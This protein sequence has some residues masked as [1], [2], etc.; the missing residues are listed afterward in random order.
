MSDI[1]FERAGVVLI[2]EFGM[3]SPE[4]IIYP[5]TLLRSSPRFPQIKAFA[6]RRITANRP[7]LPATALQKIAIAR[8]RMMVCRAPAR[9]IS[10][11]SNPLPAP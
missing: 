3:Y 2:R 10:T 9:S 1:C 5:A 4:I 11:V 8:R 7:K 6:D